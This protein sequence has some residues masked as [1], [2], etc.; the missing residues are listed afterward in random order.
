MSKT[1][2][3]LNPSSRTDTGITD[4]LA[5]SLAWCSGPA[6][7][8]IK[9]VTLTE[10]PNGIANSV[11]SD[12]SAPAIFNFIRSHDDDA[13][14]AAFVIAC[15]SDPAAYSGRELTKKP[16]IGIGEAGLATAISLGERFGTIGVSA[17]PAHK[18][19]RFVRR[20][21][22]LDRYAGHRA[23]GLDYGDL[24]YP[25]RVR[26]R[27]AAAAIDLRDRD[28]ADVIVFAGAG[29]AHYVQEVRALCGLPVVD[30]TLAGALAA[31]AGI[32]WTPAA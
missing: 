6:M 31:L 19:R 26:D 7:P 11:D 32:A 28:G 18:S 8:A 16:V 5:R 12:R 17:E 27:L 22:L 3:V 20:T 1:I 14:A 10:G 24:Q 2:Y 25:E 4:E 21:G 23:L 29:L 9:C 30:P 13:D 15:F